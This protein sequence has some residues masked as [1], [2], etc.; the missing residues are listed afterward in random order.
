MLSS[1]LVAP[2]DKRQGGAQGGETPGE[3][4]AQE[5]LGHGGH[6]RDHGAFLPRDKGT[7]LSYYAETEQ[8]LIF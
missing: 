7:R 4:G 2:D 8:E 1:Y 5:G 3:E 6:A